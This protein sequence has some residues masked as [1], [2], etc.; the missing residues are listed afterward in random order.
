MKRH[1]VR[2]WLAVTLI[3]VAGCLDVSFT[4]S[5][6]AQLHV[7]GHQ[8]TYSGVAAVDLSTNG[9][10]QSH[11][12]G[13]NGISLES[14]AVSV[15]SIDAGNASTQLTSA[16]VALR[17]DGAP[18]DGSQDVQI[19]TIS[20]P[21]QFQTYL[22]AA[23]GGGGRKFSLPLTGASAADKF[24]MDKVVRGPGKFF[25]VVQAQT[26]QAE[27]HITLQIDLVNAVSYGLL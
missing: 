14:V 12:G 11:K 6:S 20:S 21:L 27:T 8:S 2:S 3:S 18:A 26:D 16:T 22:P 1:S 25:F 9:D 13:I 19:G 10:F 15:A 17:A 5:K 4:I 24:F 7:D 23:A